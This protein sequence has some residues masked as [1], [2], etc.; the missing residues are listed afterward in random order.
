MFFLIR[1]FQ[2]A[3]EC[4]WKY[5]SILSNSPAQ[6]VFIKVMNGLVMTLKEDKTLLCVWLLYY[7]RN[8]ADSRMEVPRYQSSPTF[9]RSFFFS[10]FSCSEVL[11]KNASIRSKFPTAACWSGKKREEGVKLASQCEA[12]LLYVKSD[13]GTTGKSFTVFFA[14]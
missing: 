4:T 3:F 2:D 6:L 9:M 8:F 7:V 1:A 12:N 11:G 5:R 10:V 14:C 13:F